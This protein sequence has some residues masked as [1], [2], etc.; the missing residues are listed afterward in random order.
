M[1]TQVETRINWR[2]ESKL[3]GFVLYGSLIWI[4]AFAGITTWLKLALMGVYPLPHQLRRHQE[5]LI[6]DS[7]SREGVNPISANLSQVVIPAKAGIQVRLPYNTNPA[8]FDL[9]FAFPD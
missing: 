8:N 2:Y 3:A 9:L 7:Q 6:L 5:I 4:P 1:E